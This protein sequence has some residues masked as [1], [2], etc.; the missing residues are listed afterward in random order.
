MESLGEK[1]SWDGRVCNVLG[2]KQREV[3]I[4]RMYYHKTDG[5]AEYLTNTYIK[6]DNNHREGVLNEKTKY[7]VRLDGDIEKD[8][9]LVIIENN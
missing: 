8:A 7:I 5:G 4:M 9:G 1:S 6:C 3:I 2:L